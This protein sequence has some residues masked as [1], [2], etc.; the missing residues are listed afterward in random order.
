MGTITQALGLSEEQV[1]RLLQTAALAPSLHNTQPWR[2]RL[3]PDW[4]EVHVD[5]GRN[6]RVADPDGR[7]LRIA[8]GAALFNLRLGLIG[9]SE[10]LATVRGTVE[11]GPAPGGWRLTARLPLAKEGD[12]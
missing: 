10:R 7:E 3:T 1:R 6:L 5:R 4:I 9:L 11:T 2:F 12:E 8:G